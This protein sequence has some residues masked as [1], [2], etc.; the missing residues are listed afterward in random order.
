MRTS[1]FLRTVAAAAVLAAAGYASAAAVTFLDPTTDSATI[2]Y[3]YDNVDGA[4]LFAKVTYDL[5]TISANTATFLV[6]VQNL[7]T[8]AQPGKNRLIAFGV[9]TVAPVLTGASANPGWGATINDTFPGF[10]QIDLCVWDGANCSGGGNQGVAEGLTETLTLTLTTAGNFTTSGI[11]FS[12]PFASKWQSVGNRGKS[13]ELDGC[14][15]GA[16]GTCTPP[17]PP[18]E[19]VPEP[20]SLALVG[21]GLVAAAAARRRRRV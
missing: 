4:N 17:R 3:K 14:I 10:Q 2:V 20:A 21:L 18:Q 1:A 8:G 6:T 12:S 19:D 11:S 15:A 16:D 5:D 13:W 9:D 7:T